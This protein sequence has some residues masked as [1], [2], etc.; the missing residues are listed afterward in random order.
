MTQFY[1]AF[2]GIVLGAFLLGCVFGGWFARRRM[3]ELKPRKVN[4]CVKDSRLT[5]LIGRSRTEWNE[6]GYPTLKVPG[7]NGKHHSS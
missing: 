1:I 4:P 3:R 5:D 2:G 6:Y 7:S